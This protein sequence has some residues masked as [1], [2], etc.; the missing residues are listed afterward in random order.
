M[1]EICDFGEFR[2]F[3]VSPQLVTSKSN[4]TMRKIQKV[5]EFVAKDSNPDWTPVI[6]IGNKKSGNKDGISILA[7]F[8]SELNPAQVV[9]LDEMKMEAGL[10]WFKLL[11]KYDITSYCVV[12]G[13][14]GT[15]G[16]VNF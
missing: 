1:G 3:I 2:K 10:K 13:G 6:V 9:D 5:I 12:A 16:Y 4:R 7:A 8:R 15:V 14:D 11:D